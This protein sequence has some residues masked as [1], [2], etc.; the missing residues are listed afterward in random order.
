MYG[1]LLVLFGVIVTLLV[2]GTRIELRNT[3]THESPLQPIVSLTPPAGG[4]R[5]AFRQWTVDVAQARA[6]GARVQVAMPYTP[7]VTGHLPHIYQAG[8]RKRLVPR[9]EGKLTRAR[10]GPL[11]WVWAD[12]GP[13]FPERR[14]AGPWAAAMSPIEL[15]GR[16]A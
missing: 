11:A 7:P 4:G 6:T 8:P 15:W 13:G 16:L 12:L 14:A 2:P 5:Q 3:R 10:T 9:G 1:T